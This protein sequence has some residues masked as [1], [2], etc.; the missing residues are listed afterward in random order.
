MKRFK[1]SY[2]MVD[3]LVETVLLWV[4]ATLLCGK[5]LETVFFTLSA[6]AIIYTNHHTV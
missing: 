2:A 6:V 1:P 4:T 5:F 3:A